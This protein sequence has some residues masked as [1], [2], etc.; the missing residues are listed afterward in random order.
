MSE[1]IINKN[2][3]TQY[4]EDMQRYS[5]Y[6]SRK[7]TTPSILDGLKP[8]QR[9]IIFTMA[10][11][12]HAINPSRKVKS[13]S[14]VGQ[15]MEKYHPHGDAGIYGT[16]K[17]LT[18][19][20]EIKEPLMLGHGVF[21]S[22]QGDEMAAS[23]YTEVS[24]SPF[25]MECA[26]GDL[27]ENKNSVDWMPS[28]NNIPEPEYLPVGVPLLLIEGSFSIGVGMKVD[29]PTHNLAEV[30]DQTLK[31]IHDP[32]APIE[33]VPDHCMK[34]K[35]LD[36]DFRKISNLGYGSYKVRGIIDTE[37]LTKK[38]TDEYVGCTALVIKSTPNLTF[39]D[40]VTDK[41]DELVAN[42]VIVNIR[43]AF[44]KTT[45]SQMRYII[46]LKNGADPNFVK[47]M[48]Y[49]T[50]EME[51]N[52][53][54]NFEVLDGIEPIRV[55]YREYILRWIEF[56]KLTKFRVY[57]NELQRIQTKIHER[58]AYIKALES[59]EI[60]TIISMIRAQK[61]IDDNSNM[62][63]LIKKLHITDLQAK[64]ILNSN[65]KNLSQAYL[66]KYKAE[67]AAYE[68]KKAIYM[69]KIVHDEK[70]L[71]DIINELLYFKKKYGKPR[72][73]PVV[74]SFTDHDVP[75]GKVKIIVTQNNY[76]KKVVEN[77][78][79]GYFKNDA[80]KKVIKI[81]NTDN[82]LIFDEMG[83]V[84]KLPIDKIAFSAKNSNG[85]DIRS[86]IR[87]CTANINTVIAESVVSN[88]ND[89]VIKSYLIVA[90]NNGYM[91]KM[92][93][94]DFLTV[95]PSGIIYTKLEDGDRVKDI[96]IAADKVD[97]IVYSDRKALRVNVDSISYLKRNTRGTKGMNSDTC[98]DGISIIRQGATNILVI[99]ESGK[100][101][102]FNVNGLKYQDRG[103]NGANVIKLAKNDKIKTI[104]GVAETDII[105]VTTKSGRLDIPVSTVK[106]SSS[107]GSGEK[108]ISDSIIRCDI[109]RN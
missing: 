49:K 2:C 29:I 55:S 92:D 48:I 108:L 18:N 61:V 89:K 31:L 99:T 24:L 21:G 62:E 67:A 101:N 11:D 28:Y 26:L 12:A 104:F 70:I 6:V 76:I 90:S 17:T 109:L 65:I 88:L 100:I 40:T 38:D 39:L 7:R 85:I 96:I 43:A 25:A 27:L 107:A 103:K 33:L 56:R 30:I 52:C 1:T 75:K 80:P 93:L 34:C 36:T 4:V 10:N 23:R 44:D 83:K 71:E 35:I 13:A 8:V 82:L 97:I 64:F 68:E 9:R 41:I 91:K 37:T 102:K 105:K 22:M 94:G 14:V 106:E 59:G 3:L 98:I 58:D 74:K 57:T 42:N 66:Q 32:N 60:D 73:C 15:T 79:I 45:T 86:L 20:F 72:L 84:F 77:D 16:F 51:Q 5:I 46:V 54:V 50:T 78:S 87:G 81:D 47:E 53:R 69:D 19:W 63:Y 95:P